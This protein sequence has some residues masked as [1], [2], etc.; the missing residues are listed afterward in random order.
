M[1]KARE[2]Q[3]SIYFCYISY[4]KAGDGQGSLACCSP[5]GHKES[6]TTEQ[7]SLSLSKAFS[8][9]VV[10]HTV[11]GFSIDHEAEVDIFL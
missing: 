10:I 8:Q 3:K 1:E 2:F 7:L 11:T 9:F 6:D 4:A 5:W